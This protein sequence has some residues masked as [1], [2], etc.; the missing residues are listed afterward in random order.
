[1][2][3]LSALLSLLACTGAPTDD[4]GVPADT[5]TDDTDIPDDTDSPADEAA[6]AAAI[7]SPVDAATVT[8]DWSAHAPVDRV[9]AMVL[10]GAASE[11]QVRAC[12]GD[13]NQGDVQALWTY[14]DARD[15][16]EGTGQLELAPY[17]GSALA[18]FLV[19]T[20]RV[21]WFVDIQ[22]GGAGAIVLP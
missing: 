18:I 16:V 13:L 2:L 9:D 7:L 14:D 21:A 20:T 4:T 5:S 22:T 10:I 3:L 8:V 12:A 1:M 19:G 17:P 15:D 6:C 11:L